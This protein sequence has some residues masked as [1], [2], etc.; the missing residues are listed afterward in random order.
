MTFSLVALVTRDNMKCGNCSKRCSTKPLRNRTVLGD[1]L[2]GW[3]DSVLY[4]LKEIWYFV[5]SLLKMKAFHLLQSNFKLCTNRNNICAEC[6]WFKQ[7]FS[8]Y[9]NGFFILKMWLRI[10]FSLTRNQDLRSGIYKWRCF[11]VE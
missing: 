6:W 11:L 7:F 8:N 2:I 5:N 3:K 1:S 4:F 9:L 10:T